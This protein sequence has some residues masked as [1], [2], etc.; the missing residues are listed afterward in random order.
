MI[1]EKIKEHHKDHRKIFDQ[2]PGANKARDELK[3]YITKGLYEFTNKYCSYENNI[4]YYALAI[5]INCLSEC[6]VEIH[7]QFSCEDS[8]ILAANQEDSL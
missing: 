2:I 7:C 4:H 8:P 3:K 1:I 5:M 6:M